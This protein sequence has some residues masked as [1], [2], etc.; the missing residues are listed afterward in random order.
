MDGSLFNYQN[1]NPEEGFQ[2]IKILIDTVKKYNGVFVLLWHNSSFDRIMLRGWDQVY[3]KTL[4]YI[5]KK[6]VLNDTVREI[7]SWW[8]KNISENNN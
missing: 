2:R 8:E 3:E 1:L 4:E 6:N 5:R 7:I